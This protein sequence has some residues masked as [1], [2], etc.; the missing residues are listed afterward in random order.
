MLP[1]SSSA[2]PYDEPLLGEEADSYLPQQK[3]PAWLMSAVLHVC[4]LLLLAL[5]LRAAAPGVPGDEPDRTVGIAMKGTSE[6]ETDYFEEQESSSGGA[7]PGA[8]SLTQAQALPQAAEAPLNL[9]GALPTGEMAVAGDHGESQP[10]AGGMLEGPGTGN[11]PGDGDAIRTSVFGASGV[12]SK[13][14][15]V[16]DRSGSMDG[17]RGRPMAAAKAALLSSLQDLERTNQFQIIFYN[18]FPEEFTLPGET[19]RLHY[20][21]ETGKQEAE[22]FVRGILATGGTRHMDALRLGPADASRRDLLSHRCQRAATDERT[23]GRGASVKP[24]PHGD[25]LHRIRL[26]PGAGRRELLAAT[27]S[28]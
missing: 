5:T 9:K 27:G 26:R 10:G 24:R 15:Y 4:V 12:G 11:F 21:D 6:A 2:A 8:E 17:Y 23:T 14:V 1:A 7:A 13:F 18:E 22:R 28:R 20:G 19:P 16:F 25:S 3:L